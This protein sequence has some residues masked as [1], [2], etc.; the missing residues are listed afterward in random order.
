[1]VDGKV[2]YRFRCIGPWPSCG[3]A[4]GVCTASPDYQAEINRARKEIVS[5]IQ[6][7]MLT[8]MARAIEREMLSQEMVLTDP[9]T[10]RR[11]MAER[12]AKAALEAIR[13]PNLHILGVG[14]QVTLQEGLVHGWPAMID[15]I[16][17]GEG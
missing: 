4:E 11:M 3:H 13:E 7:T 5:M 6:P 14:S 1:M 12:A 17:T 15:A 10:L 8:R 2:S 9:L 16:L